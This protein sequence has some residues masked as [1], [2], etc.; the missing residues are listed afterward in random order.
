MPS[1]SLMNNEEEHRMELNR[2]C[3]SLRGYNKVCWIIEERCN[4]NCEFCFHSQ[5]ENTMKKIDE[6]KFDYEKIIS[7][8][9]KNNIKHVILSG[10]EPLLSPELFSIIS[11][12]ENN[13]FSISISTN[14][15]MATPQFCSQLKNTTVQKLTVNMASICD[16]NGR[17]TKVNKYSSVINGIQNL[18]SAG[19]SITLNNILRNTTT[20]DILVQNIECG[21]TLGAQEISFTVPVCKSSYECYSEF[22]YLDKYK[23]NQLKAFLIEIEQNFD[24]HIKITFNCPE[25]DSCSCPANNEIFGVNTDRILSTCLVKQYQE[26][27]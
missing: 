21:K 24:P 23:I 2:C 14:A 16:N 19:F 9:R 22:F 27:R 8:F 6:R 3:F 13:G 12:L 18:V 26:F 7:S 5:F 20:K 17:I 1:K 15:I 4:L 10:G 11:L 25:C